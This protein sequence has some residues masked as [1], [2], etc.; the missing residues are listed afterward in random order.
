M[1]YNTGVRISETAVLQTPPPLTMIATGGL[2]MGDSYS[3]PA[4]TETQRTFVYFIA[5]GSTPIKIGV[6]NDP[7]ARLADLQTA[8]YQKLTLLYS[9]ECVTRSAAFELETAFHRWY[10]EA[11]IRNE[12]FEVSPQKIA[13]DIQLLMHLAGSMVA[14]VQHVSPE[15]IEKIESR[16]AK[17][18]A[19]RSVLHTRTAD[20][21][22][23]ALEWFTANPEQA[24]RSV[25]DLER[26][27]GV[28]RDTISRA[29]RQ[30]QTQQQQAAYNAAR[31]PVIATNGHSS[32]AV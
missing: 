3:I 10:G 1:W 15:Q 26:E 18:L 31:Q 23:K 20:G 4:D 11:K 30:W 9:I 32:E 17:K 25:R 7:A 6:S 8:H 28:G 13:D 22:N 16:A 29:R 12:W 24:G 5:A 27:I 2:T 21:L 14:A 19:A